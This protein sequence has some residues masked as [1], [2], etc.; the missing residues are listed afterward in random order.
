VLPRPISDL[1]ATAGEMTVRIIFVGTHHPPV[2]AEVGIS[3]VL[4][5]LVKS[6][7]VILP[8]VKV[9]IRRVT[10]TRTS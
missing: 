2:G 9:T 7:R 10:F 5:R 8:T 6:C 3:V 4:V 1:L